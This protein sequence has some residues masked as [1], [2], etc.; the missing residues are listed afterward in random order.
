MA[1]VATFVGA[2]KAHIT[3]TIQD[4]KGLWKSVTSSHSSGRPWQ[5][6]VPQIDVTCFL[7]RMK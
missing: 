6:V 7:G 3:V 4:I 1:A 5:E 2:Q